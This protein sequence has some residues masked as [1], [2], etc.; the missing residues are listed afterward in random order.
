MT[1]FD[2]PKETI[3][4]IH[5]LQHYDVHKRAKNVGQVF[6]NHIESRI[7]TIFLLGSDYFSESST[8][9]SKHCHLNTTGRSL[10]GQKAKAA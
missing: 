4:N 8:D 5:R 10:K 2:G 3:A 6:R 9:P 1:I 7:V